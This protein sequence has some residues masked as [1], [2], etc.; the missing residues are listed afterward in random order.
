MVCPYDW[1][2]P[3][4]VKQHIRDLAEELIVQGHEVSVLTPS[5]SDAGLESYVVTSGRPV[6]VPYNGSV[7]RVSIGMVSAR[8]V[9]NWVNNGEFDVLHVHEPAAPSLSVLACWAAD[10]PLVATWHSSSERSRAMSAASSILQ[11]AME[12]ISGRIAVSEKARQTLVENLG[13]DA[14]LIPNGVACRNF[15]GTETLPGY[16]RSGPTVLFL[17]RIDE[18]RKGLHVVLPALPAMVQRHPDLELVVAG[19]GD[20]AAVEGSIDASVRDHVRFLGLISEDDKVRAF[21]SADVYLAPNT[22]G[23]SFGIVLL[24]ALAAGTAVAASDLEAFR[25]VLEDGKSGRLFRN[26]DSADLAEA[27]SELLESPQERQQ[28]QAEG[29][30]RARDFDWS[31]VARDVVRVY[32]SVIQPGVTVR[33]DFSGQLFGRLG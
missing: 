13:G 15:T 23:E 11:T 31:T 14:V 19:P 2:A 3:G 21:K 26:G 25:L 20:V 24:E 16:P 29:A 22:H 6:A 4:G 18:A 28:L 1:S 8:R 10:G 9:R 5:E 33:A 30:R 27:V 17:G 12:K 7:A 32:D